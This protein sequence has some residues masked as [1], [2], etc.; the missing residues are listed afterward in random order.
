MK[1]TAD[2]LRAARAEIAEPGL[3]CKN[4]Y[5]DGERCCAIRAL[6]LATCRLLG[7]PAFYRAR[8]ALRRA[9][10][11]GFSSVIAYNDAPTTTHADILALFDRAIAEEEA[12]P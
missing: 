2:D 4:A 8:Q 3:W 1:Q 12:N 9:L 10:P 5:E 6:E 7:W 11:E